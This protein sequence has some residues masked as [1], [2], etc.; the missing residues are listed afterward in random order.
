MGSS[1]RRP[2]NGVSTS[3][4]AKTKHT[5]PTLIWFSEPLDEAAF[6]Y[7]EADEVSLHGS[8]IDHSQDGRKGSGA[9]MP[10]VFKNNA[11]GLCDAG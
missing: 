8:E 9:E 2:A 11:R 7:W 6:G 10:N 3:D 4:G 1:A 5:K